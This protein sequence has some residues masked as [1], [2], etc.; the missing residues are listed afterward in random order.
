MLPKT[1]KFLSCCTLC[2]FLLLELDISISSLKEVIVI[3]MYIHKKHIYLLSCLCHSEFNLPCWHIYIMSCSCIGSV[4]LRS[5][6]C[7]M[8]RHGLYLKS[9][10]PLVKCHLSFWSSPFF[11]ILICKINS[12]L[13]HINSSEP[14]IWLL[15]V[16]DI[17]F[18]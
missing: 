12:S 11:Q 2:I 15:S 5:H 6:P 17:G 1:I 16:I 18:L 10:Q 3:F 8:N 4:L 13:M 14:E 9:F 7:H